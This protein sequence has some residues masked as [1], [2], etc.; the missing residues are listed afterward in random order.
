MPMWMRDAGKSRDVAARPGEARDDALLNRIGVDVAHDDG[1]RLGQAHERT[2]GVEPSRHEA[3][4]MHPQKLRRQRREQ[5]GFALGEAQLD[6]EILAVDAPQ[7]AHALEKSPDARRLRFV[8]S[9]RKP[10]DAC[11][12]LPLLR[13]SE[14]RQKAGAAE[15]QYPPAR[16]IHP[17]T[18]STYMRIVCGKLMW[19]LAGNWRRFPDLPERPHHPSRWRPPAL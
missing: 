11:H 16:A 14:S 12:F 6:G 3:V 4:G 1:Y 17:I 19:R 5:L 8:A 15:H 13:E 18:R 9:G 10:T 7:S 2:Y